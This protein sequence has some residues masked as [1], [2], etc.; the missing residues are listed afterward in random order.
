MA[1]AC[2]PVENEMRNERAGERRPPGHMRGEDDGHVGE[3]RQCRPFEHGGI[4]RVAH[5]CFEQDAD[6]AEQHGVEALGPADQQAQRRA[7]GA[8]VCAEI[9]H[10]GDEQQEHERAQSHGE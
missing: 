7:H 4:A 1:M 5:E 2:E 3:Q 8:E 9:D 6:D 10:I